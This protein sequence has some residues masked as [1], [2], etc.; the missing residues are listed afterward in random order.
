MLKVYRLLS[1]VV[2][3]FHKTNFQENVVGEISTER[4]YFT[5]H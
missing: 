2:I 3:D 5:Q 4:N 1:Y